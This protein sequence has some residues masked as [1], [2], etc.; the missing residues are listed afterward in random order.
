MWLNR[1]Y[2]NNVFATLAYLLILLLGILAYPQLPR[3]Q[4]PELSEKLAMVTITLT[5]ASAE[6]VERLVVDPIEKM[7]REK[8][9]DINHVNSNAATGSASVNIEFKDI[10][11]PLYERRMQELRREL[12]ALALAN[13]PKAQPPDVQEANS[14][15]QDW[16]KVLVYGPGND[17]NFRRQARQVQRDLQ[18]L[19]G[20]TKVFNKG[21]EDAEHQVVFQPERLASLGIDS[22][23][24]TSTIQAYFNDTT[25][26]NVKV[27]NRDWMVRIAGKEN[28]AANLANL[29]I[30]AAKGLVKLGEVAEITRTSQTALLGARFRGQ[31][32]IVLMPFKQ[33]GANVLQLIDRIKAY[34][35]ERN[36]ASA[37]TGVKLY[38]LIDTSDTI[39]NSLKVM[40]DHAWSGML[41]VL[42]VTW[43]MLGTRLSLL[44]T[45]AVPFSLAGVFIALQLAEKSLNL[46]VLL[47]V[48]IVLGMLVDDAVVVI[49]AIGQ[50]LR[51]G[52]SSLEA[53]TSALKEVWLPVATSSLTTIASFIPLMLVG[54]FLGQV[55]G[56][57]PQVVCLGLLVSLVQA[58]WILPAQAVVIVK[59][60][61]KENWRDR[62]R[63]TLQLTYT[64]LLIR[65]FRAPKRALAGLAAVFLLAGSAWV[66]DWVKADYLLQ[67]PNY[68]FFI[69]LEMPVGTDKAKTL[70]KME[71][72]EALVTPLFR[73]GELRASAIES[74]IVSINGKELSGHQY[75][76]IWF[77]MNSE[78]GR[79]A[80][81]L[82]PEVK[83]AM[84]KL[85]GIVGVWVEGESTALSMIGKPINL[86]LSGAAGAELDAAITELKG[87]LA[88]IPGVHDSKLDIVT[89]LPE[90]LIR[91]DGEAIQRA[92]LNPSTVTQTLQ[93]LTGGESVASYTEEGETVSVRVRAQR[94]NSHDIT[95]LLQRTVVTPNGGTMPLS[96]LVQAEQRLSPANITHSDYKRIL[97]LQ[98]ELDKEKMDT[99]AVNKLIQE[100]WNQAKARYPNINVDLGGEMLAIQEGL[101]QLWQQFVLGLGLI[102][103]IVGA[104]FRSYGL[105]FLVLFKVP[106]AFTGLVLGLLIS[107]EPISLYT[108]YGAVALAGIAVNSAILMFSAGH[109]R[110][111][112]GMGVV[113]ASVYAAR[114]RLLPILI[115]SSTTFMGLLPLA[116]SS[117]QSSTQWRPVATAIV[118]GVGFST[119]LT[120][121]I[122]PLLY[123]LAM[124]F[125]FKK[126]KP[127]PAHDI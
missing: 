99:L 20:V 11:Q 117:E 74:G 42:A 55:M 7:L 101:G 5:D 91:L 32:C 89:G 33:P 127:N 16:Y 94:D 80:S 25:A 37:S 104:Q 102:F 13:W 88:A 30:M 123:R 76:D 119:I 27:D 115:T 35:D 114:R 105:P 60:E 71:D 86:M 85:T 87:I 66:F 4:A 34:I 81:A 49:E 41:L 17:D 90:L 112:A 125:S 92:G 110:L 57:V 109:D 96:Q 61:D 54:G 51:R 19:P 29:P 82:L 68:G 23:A 106:M 22:N 59:P 124:G 75:G 100:R 83:K 73:P 24:L 48:V 2:Q 47:G 1:L 63:Q 65:L 50:H 53:T 120:L 122:V 14:F 3:E 97:T 56:I 95:A 107:R 46:S 78:A 12:Q 113:H 38:L 39:R 28:P 58:L 118:W 79:D 84:A 40:E 77:S 126:A 62:F 67:P 10:K 121:F 31:P 52:L 116:L 6:D 8:I 44:T 93:L 15:S 21:L 18:Q 111:A 43:L 103:I 108:L 45:L 9:K 36:Q 72:I 98:A 64:R 70:A 26:G 69:K